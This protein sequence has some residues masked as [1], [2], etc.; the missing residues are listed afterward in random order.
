MMP[1]SCCSS[2]APPTSTSAVGT[3]PS[4][5]ERGRAVSLLTVQAQIALS[6]REL[7]Q[8]PY[9]FCSTPGCAAVYFTASAPPVTCDQLRER[10]FQ[11]EPDL[12]VLVCYCFR[13]SRGAVQQADSI[14]RAAILADV[15]AGTQ[16]GQ[17]ACE[18]R[19]PQGSCCLGNL[20]RLAR[21]RTDSSEASEEGLC[22]TTN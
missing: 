5:G 11:K 4:C 2:S 9:W 13:Y 17:C 8:P 14:T 16:Q 15:V 10:V 7:G 3:C 20:R 12:D 18:I 22:R 6:L 19:N 1:D 21:E